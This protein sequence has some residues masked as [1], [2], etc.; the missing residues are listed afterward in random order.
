M[1]KDPSDYMELNFPFF[2]EK[3]GDTGRMYVTGIASDT[4]EDRDKERLSEKALSDACEY[5]KGGIESGSPI[6]LLPSH[7][8]SFRVGDIV[9]SDVSF[10]ERVVKDS[11]GTE[12]D[13]KVFELLIKAVLRDGHPDAIELFENKD[14]YQMS[15]GFFIDHSK[16]DAVYFE[17]NSGGGVRRVVN[18]I[19]LDHIAVTRKNRAANQRARFESAFMKGV[20]VPSCNLSEQLSAWNKNEPIQDS[21][22]TP[23][24]GVKE[25]DM[26]LDKNGVT[27]EELLAKGFEGRFKNTLD[28]VGSSGAKQNIEEDAIALKT[29]QADLS[30]II[31]EREGAGIPVTR[32]ELSEV[33]VEWSKLGETL[34]DIM[35]REGQAN[36]APEEPK[37]PDQA[38]PPAQ[39]P[40]GAKAD[41]S[42]DVQD[43]AEPSD[44]PKVNEPDSSD[45]SA[46]T[47]DDASMD[48]QGDGDG[49]DDELKNSKEMLTEIINQ[50]ISPVSEKLKSLQD[51]L[52]SLKASQKASTTQARSKQA[53]PSIQS[54][55]DEPKNPLDDGDVEP[56][57]V[58]GGR[59]LS[60]LNRAGVETT[61]LG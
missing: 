54:K 13:M 37:E 26:G 9:D 47:D 43:Q 57:D 30:R 39:E 17:K 10:G 16:S 15:L 12:K 58:F 53:S 1:Y 61:P 48:D 27:K 2:V 42:D 41:S 3:D 25:Q 20:E 32:E 24:D 18:H 60:Q 40:Q 31:K 7:R 11:D 51:E 34:K 36:Q 5:I 44:E 45:A 6:W 22:Q 33:L 52:D 28:T 55:G 46:D 49:G 59:I 19:L 23:D 14:K 56:S 29:V 38:D 21:K 8:A 50:A 35:S 4:L